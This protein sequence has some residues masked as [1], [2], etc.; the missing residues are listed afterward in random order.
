MPL[1]CGDIGPAHIIWDVDGVAT[2]LGETFGGVVFTDEAKYKEIFEDKYGE[3]PVDAV[4]TGRISTLTAKLTRSTLA[5]L[6]I[7]IPSATVVGDVMTVK[8]SVGTQMRANAKKVT[9]KPVKDGVVSTTATE[10]LTLMAAYPVTKPSFTFDKENQRTIEA[11]FL[12]F[13]STTSGETNTIW[14]A[15]V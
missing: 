15:G 10:W 12:C 13:P 4:F 8:A 7:V 3:S 14:K 1:F 2:D 9:I 5:Q 6:A 11:T